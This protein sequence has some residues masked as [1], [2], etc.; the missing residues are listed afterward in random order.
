MWGIKK[1]HVKKGGGEGKWEQFVSRSFPF[2]VL[3]WWKFDF[4]GFC[5]GDCTGLPQLCSRKKKSVHSHTEKVLGAHSGLTSILQLQK[6]LSTWRGWKMAYSNGFT[7]TKLSEIPDR[8]LV[9][10][11]RK[12]YHPEQPGQAWKVGT[13][14]PIKVW[15]G[16][17]QDV[18]LDLR[19]SQIQG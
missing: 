18:T 1:F 17:M 8:K 10:Q 12:G 7:H 3:V 5:Y 6:S 11:I 4:R 16:Q 19:Q 13:W 15:Q 9:P 2:K 14:K